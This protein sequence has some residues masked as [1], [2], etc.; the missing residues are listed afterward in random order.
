MRVKGSKNIVKKIYVDELKA[1]MCR[2]VNW[3]KF[4][5]SLKRGT[6]FIIRFDVDGIEKKDVWHG[7]CHTCETRRAKCLSF[8]GCGGRPFHVKCRPFLLERLVS[9]R[10]HLHVTDS[11]QELLVNPDAWLPH[12]HPE[13]MKNAVWCTASKSLGNCLSLDAVHW[14]FTRNVPP[15]NSVCC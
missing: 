6:T 8:T 15:W 12:L 11:A 14:K 3:I 4:L 13:R 10:T 9:S 7:P 2:T 5:S 1:K